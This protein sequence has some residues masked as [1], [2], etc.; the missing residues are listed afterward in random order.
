MRIFTLLCLYFLL[1][2]IS[3]FAQNTYA[4]KGA[5]TDSVEHVKLGNASIVILEAKDS[6]MVKFTRTTAD[7]S[8]DIAGLKKGK[9]IL[10]ASYP[11]YAD[12]TES[13]SLDSGH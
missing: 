10:L 6:I 9:Y 5:T 7:G 2:S 8:F 13:F 12:Y 4:A 11:D 1:F 3:A